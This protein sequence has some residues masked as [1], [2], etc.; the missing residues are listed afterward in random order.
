MFR[1]P[2]DTDAIVRDGIC[3]H[4]ASVWRYALNLKEISKIFK[5]LTIPVKIDTV[6]SEYF[7]S[8]IKQDHRFI[9]RLTR[10]MP[11]FK[12]FASA[13]ATIAGIKVS[14]M[15]RKGQFGT[16]K[17]GFRQFAELAA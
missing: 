1:R 2:K 9:K 8:I 13:A 5:R 7:N 4:Y 10:P 15:I 14:H 17:C 3:L 16:L 6:R 11:G 12:S